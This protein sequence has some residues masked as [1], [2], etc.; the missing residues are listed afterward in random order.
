MAAGILQHAD[1]NILQLQ[2]GQQRADVGE[3]FMKCRGFQ[4]RRTPELRL[5]GVQHGMAHFM[6]DD[7]GT[8]AGIDDAEPGAAM[9]EIQRLAIIIGVEV[10][11]FVE[12]NRQGRASL[13]LQHSN[14]GLPE[15]AGSAQRLDRGPVAETGRAALIFTRRRCNTVAGEIKC[16]RLCGIGCRTDDGGGIARVILPDDDI[17]AVPGWRRVVASRGALMCGLREMRHDAVRTDEAEHDV[18][19]WKRARCDQMERQISDGTDR[20]RRTI[21]VAA[22]HAVAVH[23]VGGTEDHDGPFRRDFR[24]GFRCR[25]F[26]H[27]VLHDVCCSF[28]SLVLAAG[29]AASSDHVRG[30]HHHR[31]RSDAS[32]DRVSPV[33]GHC[34]C[35]DHASEPACTDVPTGHAGTGAGGEVPVCNARRRLAPGRTRTGARTDARCPLPWRQRG[36]AAH[37][38]RIKC[39]SRLQ[40]LLAGQSLPAPVR[41]VRRRVLVSFPGRGEVGGRHATRSLRAASCRGRPPVGRGSPDGERRT[42]NGERR[43]ANG[44]RRTA[45]SYRSRYNASHADSD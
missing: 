36:R 30:C 11:T 5:D 40:V 12:Q 43:T 32:F 21:A 31:T 33:T 29:C 45:L 13:P 20:F 6:A 14:D 42:A 19:G 2:G 22:V 18:A 3:G 23:A 15:I 1:T 17:R 26:S 8:F 24:C 41:Q 44:E 9:E 28:R 4:A 27:F 38:G 37:A 35:N 16:R 10:D 39:C 25:C 7:I 34:T